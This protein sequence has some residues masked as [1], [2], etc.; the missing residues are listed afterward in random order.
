MLNVNY[1]LVPTD[2]LKY[3]NIPTDIYYNLKI[4]H[5]LNTLLFIIYTI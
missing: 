5:L 4:K 3:R 2:K 1:S